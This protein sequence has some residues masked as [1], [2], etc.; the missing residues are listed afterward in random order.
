VNPE[1][2]VSVPISL[3]TNNGFEVVKAEVITGDQINSL[4]DFDKEEA[5]N[6]KEFKD[7]KMKDTELLAELPAKSIVLITIKAK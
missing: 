3:D 7:F 5:V 1:N 4:N 2:K 6:I